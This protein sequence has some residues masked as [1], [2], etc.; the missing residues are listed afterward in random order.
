M[1]V[2]LH[3]MFFHSIYFYFYLWLVFTSKF[4]VDLSAKNT[5]FFHFSRHY[6]LLQR[7]SSPVLDIKDPFHLTMCAF[8]AF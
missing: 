3:I 1:T 6:F 5:N 4:K 7:I 2:F 8:A